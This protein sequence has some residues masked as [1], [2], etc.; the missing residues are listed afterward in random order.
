S[1]N[2]KK[3]FTSSNTKVVKVAGSGK[4]TIVGAGKAVVRVSVA[5]NQI[6]MAAAAK[7]AIT[8]NPNAFRVTANDA[9]KY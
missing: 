1:S 5:A 8:V 3:S 7:V 4:V 9:S 2:D 6:F